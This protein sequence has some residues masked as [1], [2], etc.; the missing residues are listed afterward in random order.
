[1][2]VG[3]G[4][5]VVWSVSDFVH[6]IFSVTSGPKKCTTGGGGVVKVEIVRSSFLDDS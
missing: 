1:M 6:T 5:G 4:G 2:C 3:E